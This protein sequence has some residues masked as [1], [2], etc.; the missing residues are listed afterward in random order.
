MQAYKTSYL[1]N[2]DSKIYVQGQSVHLTGSFITK[3]GAGK[4]SSVLKHFA[5]L[6]SIY[7]TT[8]INSQLII[9]QLQYSI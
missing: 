2:W 7:S 8:K 3:Q 5:N 1:R 4:Y 6:C 9:N